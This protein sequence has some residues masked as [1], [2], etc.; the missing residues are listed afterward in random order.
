MHQGQESGKGAVQQIDSTPAAGTHQLLPSRTAA[1]AF[2]QQHLRSSTSARN[3]VG[4]ANTITR[5]NAVR[6]AAGAIGWAGAQPFSCCGIRAGF[7]GI[8]SVRTLR[9]VPTNQRPAWWVSWV[10][11]QPQPTS[12]QQRQRDA[13]KRAS[14]R[15]QATDVGARWRKKKVSFRRCRGNK[16]HHTCKQYLY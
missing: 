7:D 14:K 6:G 4:E 3:R 15:R 9:G 13:A 1:A 5:R 10:L 12:N 11:P 8:M 2:E 16:H